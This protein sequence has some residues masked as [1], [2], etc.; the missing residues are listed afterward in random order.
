MESTVDVP[1]PAKHYQKGDPLYVQAQQ[2]WCILTGFA[3]QRKYPFDDR[4]SQSGICEL[5]AYGELAEIMGRPGGGNML[6]R[7]LGI[8]GR[9]CV[10]NNLPP[11]NIIVVNKNSELPGDGAVL[12][13]GRTIED[14]MSAVASFDW[15]TVRPPTIGALRKVYD[16]S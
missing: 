11:L 5:I 12:R 2:I 14:E 10:M 6:G 15:F 16:H 7:Q 8:V 1:A 3:M 4:G 9:Y 13:S